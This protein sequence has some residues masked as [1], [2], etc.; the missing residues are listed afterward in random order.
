MIKEKIDTVGRFA[1][2]FFSNRL[3][4]TAVAIA[5]FLSA[6]A[7][8]VSSYA[9]DSTQMAAIS[10][11]KTTSELQ[12]KTNLPDIVEVV[13]GTTATTATTTGA[14]TLTIPNTTFTTTTVTAKTTAKVISTT[15]STPTTTTTTT[16]TTTSAVTTVGTTTTA[17]VEEESDSNYS[18]DTNAIEE[19]EEYEEEVEEE[20]TDSEEDS[21]TEDYEDSDY[22]EDCD[23]DEQAENTYSIV[24]S[25][26][27][28]ILLCN[29][30]GHEAG[31]NWI[32]TADKA[33]VVEV[34]LNRANSSG[35]S[36]YAVLT[37]RGQFSGCWSYV[38]LGTFS[39][40]VTADVIAAVDGYLSGTYPN[41]GYTRF[42]GDGRQNHFS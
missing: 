41:H 39:R 5:V 3:I 24:V 17:A 11:S 16:T 22:S 8:P 35:S 13:T 7:T 34:I 27:D 33:K 31:S 37:A 36:I 30:V 20:F 29:A 25:D 42:Y 26:S 38:N 14:V 9:G 21:E 12:P 40:N 1:R 19:Y 28:Y 6:A 2:G 23:S 10:K 4:P 18:E 32:S 15:T